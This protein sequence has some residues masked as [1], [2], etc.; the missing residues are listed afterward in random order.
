[1]YYIIYIVNYSINNFSQLFRYLTPLK[2]LKYLDLSQNKIK[3]DD[4]LILYNVADNLTNLEEL[5]L[6]HT[7]IT[8][9]SVSIINKTIF[10]LISLKIISL[11]STNITI[12]I[13]M[14]LRK[15]HQNVIFET[16]E[17]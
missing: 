15:F 5:Y 9:S 16:I 1:M 3:D 2:R 4:I 13:I 14:Y 17:L 8:S 6:H 10:K 7:N 12:E 11:Y